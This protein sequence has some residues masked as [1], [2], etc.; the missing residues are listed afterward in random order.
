[1]RSTP[2]ILATVAAALAALAL[3]ACG[4]S[5][6]GSS[7]TTGSA[8]ALTTA[9]YQSPAT[10]SLSGKRGGTL[11]VLQ[12]S[13]FEHLD[14]GITYAALDYPVVFATPCTPTSPTRPNPRPT[15]PPAR[16]KCPR[17][18]RPSPCT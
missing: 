15:W 2:T 14:P 18:T 13:D 1:M 10:E 16:R 17:T 6:S 3:A 7:T 11:V 4:S 12:E 9:G 8:S 5:E